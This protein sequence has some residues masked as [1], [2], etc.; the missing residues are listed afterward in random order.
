MQSQ[1]SLL[2]LPE[3]SIVGAGVVVGRD[4]G[5][6][7]GA[8]VG[9]RLVGASDGA[10]G[11]GVTTFALIGGRVGAGETESTG[12]SVGTKVIG[13][14][15][16]LEVG[17]VVGSGV[18]TEVESHISRPVPSSQIHAVVGYEVLSYELCGFSKKSIAWGPSLC[19]NQLSVTQR[20][21]KVNEHNIVNTNSTRLLFDANYK[22]K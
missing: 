13:L 2:L 1:L 19:F 11:A 18:T 9:S 5:K 3:S 6:S 20:G 8:L 4:V 22:I 16:G 21:V 12:L 17:E 15:V 14:L 10:V 7:E